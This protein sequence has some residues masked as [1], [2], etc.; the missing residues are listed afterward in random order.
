MSFLAQSFIVKLQTNKKSNLF[1]TL[2]FTH[3]STIIN[4]TY[5]SSICVVIRYMMLSTSIMYHEDLRSL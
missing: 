1:W 2:V 4:V 5:Y 3:P